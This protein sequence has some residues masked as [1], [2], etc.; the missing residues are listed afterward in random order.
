[1]RDLL[2]TSPATW[3]RASSSSRPLPADELDDWLA[4]ARAGQAVS[5]SLRGPGAEAELDQRL[6]VGRADDR[7]AVDALERELAHAA[8]ADGVH[9]RLERRAR[10]ARRPRR[11]APAG[12]CRR[13]RRRARARRRRA[14]R[15]RR[16]GGPAGARVALRPAQRGAV[17]LRGVG[18]GEHERRR[19]VVVALR[20][21]ALDRARERELRAA[22][23]LDE[24][25]AARD[26]DRLERGELVVERGEAA[27]DA[28]GQ[29][30]LAG[31]DAVAL[32]QQLGLG[33]AAL[34]GST[35]ARNRFA[36]SDQRPWTCAARPGS[37]PA[38]GERAPAVGA[39]LL[40]PRRAAASASAAAR[41]RRWSPRPPTR[42]PTAPPGAPRW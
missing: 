16:P 10:C 19:L 24:V 11:R 38:R 32:E 15:R 13:A 2:A 36:V 30:L 39:R 20:A 27:R 9:E 42:G 37:A 29:H 31:D 8:A 12:P 17:G 41:T 1:M 26:A 18:G 33:A 5:V 23:A 4:G 34:A 35:S 7:L 22:E 40:R 25:A 6:L 3:R 21:Q 28:L 14:R